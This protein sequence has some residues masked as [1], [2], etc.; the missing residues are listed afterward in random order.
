MADRS[1]GDGTG[2]V[3]DPGAGRFTFSRD[4]HH[5]ELVVDAP[6]GRLVLVHTGVPEAMEGG[7]VGG[8]LVQAAIDHARA[9]HLVL[10]AVC[11][12][13]RSWI[14]RHPDAVSGLEVADPQA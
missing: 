6:P 3:W 4:G 11:P 8:R 5:A 10:V 13:A 9:G 2:V 7:G 1:T 14:E 12:F